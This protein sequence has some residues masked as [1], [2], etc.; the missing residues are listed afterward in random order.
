MERKKTAHSGGNAAN[1][2]A[3]L[4]ANI[5]YINDTIAEI[6]N[7]PTILNTILPKNNTAP[8]CQNLYPA[9]DIGIISSSFG[10]GT[11]AA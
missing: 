3:G 11:N 8:I 5:G 2:V 9:I 4:R 7:A 6:P 10:S 1:H